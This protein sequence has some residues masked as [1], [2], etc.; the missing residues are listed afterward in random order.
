MRTARKFAKF[1]T[2]EFVT[3]F[4]VLVLVPRTCHITCTSVLNTCTFQKI[5]VQLQLL[6]P[7]LGL[8]KIDAFG[9]VPLTKMATINTMQ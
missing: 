1:F 7:S 5:Y 8:V 4:G 9:I 3:W 6:V 2:H